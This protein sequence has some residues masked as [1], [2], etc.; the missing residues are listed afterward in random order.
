MESTSDRRFDPHFGAQLLLE[1]AQEKS[2]A[3]LLKKIVAAVERTQ[4]M[5][6][7]VWLIEKGDRCTTC[8]YR[9][10]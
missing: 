4:F 3:P 1:M 9:P 7:Q 8:K 10:E 2:L 6:A 5:F